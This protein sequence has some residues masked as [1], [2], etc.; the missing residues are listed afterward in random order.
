MQ[1]PIEAQSAVESLF[2]RGLNFDLYPVR[3]RND[4]GE[5]AFYLHNLDFELLE[6]RSDRIVDV[7]VVGLRRLGLATRYNR[8][9]SSQGGLLRDPRFKRIRQSASQR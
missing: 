2:R 5:Y 1:F 3:G 7:H 9:F 8:K 6:G 4:W